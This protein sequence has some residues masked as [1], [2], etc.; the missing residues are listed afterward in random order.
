MSK[1]D[2][3]LQIIQ[4][5]LGAL[6]GLPVVGPASLLAGVF[7]AIFQK[8]TALYQAE[9]GLPFDISLIPMETPLPPHVAAMIAQPA[10]AAAPPAKA[11]SVT[12]IKNYG[13]A[14]S[15]SG[16]PSAAKAT[17]PHS[18]C[19]YCGAAGT[20]TGATCVACGKVHQ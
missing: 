14:A 7:L 13:A 15:S 19:P 9:S 20:Q 6:S 16:A 1:L 17:D 11:G 2:Q 3:I 8:A 4:I 12:I 18:R 5:A 10:A